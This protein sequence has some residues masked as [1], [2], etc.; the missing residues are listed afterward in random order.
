VIGD[1]ALLL[2]DKEPEKDDRAAVRWHVRFLQ[3]VPN[4]DL[5]ENQGPCPL[6]AGGVELR[7]CRPV[8]SGRLET[9]RSCAR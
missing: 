6:V 4:V 7:P 3:E 8:M 2:A 5:R 1:A 9:R